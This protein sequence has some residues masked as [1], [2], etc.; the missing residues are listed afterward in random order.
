MCLVEQ[1]QEPSRMGIPISSINER[2]D[3][4]TGGGIKKDHIVT[5]GH[6]DGDNIGETLLLHLFMIVY[7][8]AY[9]YRNAKKYT[10]ML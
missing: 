6:D 4:D 3:S 7:Q 8:A 10:S 2:D 1:K 9:T 5:V